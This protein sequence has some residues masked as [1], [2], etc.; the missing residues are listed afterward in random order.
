MIY[1]FKAIKVLEINILILKVMK[2]RVSR[3]ARPF[4]KKQ[5]LRIH[6]YEFKT[7]YKATIIK[8]V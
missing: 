5:N 3:I 4:E 6:T 1:S 8:T 2:F 7:C